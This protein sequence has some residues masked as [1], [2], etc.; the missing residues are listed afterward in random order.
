MSVIENLASTGRAYQYV[1]TL[2]TKSGETTALGKLAAQDKARVVPVMQVTPAISASFASDMGTAWAGL[3]LVLDGSNEASSTGSVNSFNTLFATLGARGVRVYPLVDFGAS[4]PY[5]Q[6]VSVAANQFAQGIML[7]VPID[8]T[9]NALAW[10][11]QIGIAPNTVDLL[12]DCG[13]VAEMS[14]SLLSSAVTS[15]INAA[16]PLSGN[17][18]SVTLTSS[19]A[20][21]DASSLSVG[22]NLVPRRDWQLWQAVVP[23]V[24]G[25]LHFGDYGMAH[26]DL[27]EPPGFAMANATVTVRYAGDVDWLIK[28]GVSTRGTNGRPMATQYHA[29]SQQL[30]AHSHFGGVPGC[31]GDVQISQIAS[32]AGAGK[33]RN[34]GTWVSLGLN[35]HLSVVAARLP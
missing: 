31:W 4:G 16:A 33:S 15:A 30:V 12:I 28:K 29:H 5:L 26:R 24:G 21:K 17:W 9:Q 34:R 11:S 1:P 20:P 25:A 3:P 13:H 19:A 6:A 22:V 2:R 18:R 27:S 35:R 10:L 32:T 14:P 8:Q 23:Q 7:R